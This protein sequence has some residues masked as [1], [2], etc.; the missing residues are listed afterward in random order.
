MPNFKTIKSNKSKNN[1]SKM[2][3]LEL[4]LISPEN[5]EKITKSN[6]ENFYKSL[7]NILIGDF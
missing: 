2:A 6:I 4:V 1:H 7:T 5:S 3:S